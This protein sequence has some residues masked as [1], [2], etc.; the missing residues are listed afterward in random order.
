MWPL[1]SAISNR[2]LGRRPHAPRPSFPEPTLDGIAGALRASRSE[3]DSLKLQK[4]AG[5]IITPLEAAALMEVSPR[6]PPQSQA[7]LSKIATLGEFASVAPQRFTR[8]ALAENIDVYS[9][10]SVPRDRKSLILGFSGAAG[11]LMLPTPCFLQ[12]LSSDRYDVV[13]LRDR[14]KQGYVFG[15]PPYAQNLWDLIQKLKAEL[16]AASYRRVYPYGTS[17][18]GFPALRC[19]ILLKTETAIS[20]GGQFPWYPGHLTQKPKRNI[21]SFDPLCACNAKTKTTLIC[22]HSTGYPPDVQS[23]DILARMIPIERVPIEAP[24]HAFLDI[25]WKQ[26][27]LRAFYDRLF[28][29]ESGQAPA[30]QCTK[31][32]RVA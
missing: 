10:A 14:T 1:I 27:R 26:G 9:D 18:G 11:Q 8:Q 20:G 16:G 25:L 28:G 19:G 12:Y 24:R 30:E 5:G 13:M 4:W 2:V 17:M 6:L 32:D 31:T 3:K 23:V 29:S 7:W 22:Y 15:I 21:P